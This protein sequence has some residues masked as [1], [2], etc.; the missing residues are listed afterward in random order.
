MKD[1]TLNQITFEEFLLFQRAQDPLK[2]LDDVS[3]DVSK[4]IKDV[5]KNGDSALLKY[6]E[7]FD[8]L[9]ISSVEELSFDKKDMES[10]FNSIDEEIKIS[11]GHLKERIHKSHKYRQYE[12]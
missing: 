3:E 1:I 7:K 12:Y 5:K 4:I 11:L 10:A 8:K 9:K 6:T 2:D